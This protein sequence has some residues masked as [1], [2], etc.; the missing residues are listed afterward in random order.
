MGGSVFG[1]M[2]KM[3]HGPGQDHDCPFK[4]TL[5]QVLC[6]SS[7]GGAFP[8]SANRYELAVKHVDH[9]VRF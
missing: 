6:L 9:G 7:V 5:C 8:C 1:V 2:T 4:G 3:P